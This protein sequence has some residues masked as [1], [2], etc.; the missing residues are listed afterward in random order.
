MQTQLSRLLQL[1][2]LDEN[3]FSCNHHLA[4]HFDALFGGQVL[5][6]S[7][8]AASRTVTDRAV[9]SVH[10]YFLRAGSRHQPLNFTVDRV[11]DGGSFSMRNVVACQQG[12]EIFHLLAS[13][14]Q[15]ES[16][17]RHQQAF[18]A[19]IAH[20]DI[21]KLP[22][23]ETLASV[24]EQAR[25]TPEILPY[26]QSASVVVELRPISIDGYLNNKVSFEKGQFWFRAC[27]ELASEQALQRAALAFASD[28]CLAASSSFQHPICLF[29][30]NLHSASLDHAMWFHTDVDMTQ[31]HLYITDSPWAGEGR[32]LNYG[33]IYTRDGRLV[34][35]TMQEGLIRG[36][37]NVLC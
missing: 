8:L 1:E 4:N 12:K 35:T 21:Q 33:A 2:Q 29:D 30:K 3:R 28:R 9:H 25:A 36:V 5:A 31:W 11:R 6:Q 23:P 13:F 26:L 18:P 20:G 32:G 19:S 15:P 24:E 17:I 7:L 16:G 37:E 10:A 14:H 22:Q 34:A 27:G